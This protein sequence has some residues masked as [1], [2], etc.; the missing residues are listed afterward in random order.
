MTT[1]ADDDVAFAFQ[2]ARERTD[3]P[4]AAA[5]LA[6]AA[7]MVEQLRASTETIRLGLMTENERVRHAKT[8]ASTN[9]EMER[10]ERLGQR[11]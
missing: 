5:I 10:R 3:D 9:R 6:H 7:V 8:V 1:D 4:V 2:A 11:F